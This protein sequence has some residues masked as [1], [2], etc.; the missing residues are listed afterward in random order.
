[1]KY[2]LPIKKRNGQYEASNTTSSNSSPS[3]SDM[4]PR[5]L[6]NNLE[7]NISRRTC[8]NIRT[9][10]I[11]KKNHCKKISNWMK[12]QMVQCYRWSGNG[13]WLMFSTADFSTKKKASKLNEEMAI[14][15]QSISRSFPK[16]LR[17]ITLKIIKEKEKQTK[18][19][20]WNSFITYHSK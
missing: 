2:H 8:H 16:P 14:Y 17:T 20:S 19:Q 11:K 18:M 3:H 13:T 1:M 6:T 4:S 7:F 15:L 9:C 5:F 12:L 10:W